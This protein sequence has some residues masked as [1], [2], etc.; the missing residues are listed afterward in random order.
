MMVNATYTSKK[1]IQEIIDSQTMKV[2]LS[3]KKGKRME[4]IYSVG[5]EQFMAPEK[6][7]ETDRRILFGQNITQ[8]I[9]QQLVKEVNIHE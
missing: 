1:Q 3:E 4:Y 5:T 2:W 7:I 9:K 8:K 6:I